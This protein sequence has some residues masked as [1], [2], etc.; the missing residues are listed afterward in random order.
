MNIRKLFKKQERLLC[1]AVVLAAGDST[2]MGED[3][4][5][6][7]LDGMPV[8]IRSIKAF[9]DSPFVG[10]II[11]VTKMDRVQEMADAVKNAGFKKVRKVIA[12]G[13]TRAESSLAG[14]SS[15]SKGAEYIA[16]HDCARPLVTQELI[17]AVFEGAK[18]YRAAVPVI[19]S[20]DTLKTV[21]DGFL[22]G[23][24]DRESVV[25]IQTPQIFEADIIKGALTYAVEHNLAVTDDS[26]AAELFGFK[27]RAV[28]GDENNIKLT[29]P[30][31]LAVARS[32]LAPGGRDE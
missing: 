26:S 31:D 4:S 13:A 19:P 5:L 15:V 11:L 12:G 18:K 30:S 16:I 27:V 21:S 23:N 8:F 7:L 32:I 17:E 3:K 2:R 28:P 1:S 25:R 24:V 14:V 20:T 9:E 29:K 10:E 6:I 22:S